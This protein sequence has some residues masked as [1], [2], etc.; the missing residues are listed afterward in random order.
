MRK[1][2][3]ILIGAALLPAAWAADVADAVM[4]QDPSAVRA[5]LAKKSDVNAAQADGTTALD[6]AARWN[7]LETA[8]LLIRAGADAG[9]TNHDGATPMFLA[10]QNGSAPMIELLLKAVANVN[11]PVLS[12]G[13][14]ALMMASRSGNVDA[15]KMLLDHGAQI[16]AKD[17]LRGTTAL[18]WASEQG[19]VSVVE[20]LVHSGADV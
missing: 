10:S 12:H 19:H 2:A 14:T 11:A 5:L 8:G 17:T 16:N 7:D 1:F 9:T 18:M 3:V 4:N 15:V 13:E 6:W 20:V